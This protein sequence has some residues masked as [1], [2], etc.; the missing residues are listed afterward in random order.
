MKAVVIAGGNERRGV[1]LRDNL[2]ANGYYSRFCHSLRDFCVAINERKIET[3]I[4]LFP[5]EFGIAGQLFEKDIRPILADDMR[6]VFISTSTT[7][8]NRA[9]S[10]YYCADEF[11]IEPI[12][13]GEIAKIIDDLI[14]SRPRGDEEFILEIGDLVLNMETL[15]VTWR[16]KRLMLYPRQV[17]I[18]EFL[19]RNHGRTI[20]RTELLNNV[21]STGV[22]MEDSTIDRNVKRIR[23]GFRRVAKIDPIRTVHRV[24]YRFNDQF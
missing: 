7:E 9:R 17:R 21:W 23:D 10:F 19:M 5:D 4:V 20:T 12:S 15:V 3:V 8:N 22:N 6:V 18:L 1:L 14:D 13:V 24:G 11:L 2:S 16:N